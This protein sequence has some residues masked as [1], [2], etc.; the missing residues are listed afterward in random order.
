MDYKVAFND[1]GTYTER[2]FQK[3]F[4]CAIEDGALIITASTG[5]AIAVFAP[6]EWHHVQAVGEA[7]GQD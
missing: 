2:V 5:R 4:T 1:A 7:S 6:Q 3:A